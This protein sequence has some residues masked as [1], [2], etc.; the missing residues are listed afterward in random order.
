MGTGA[1]GS[2]GNSEGTLEEK[3]QKWDIKW[4]ELRK[5]DLEGT[6]AEKGSAKSL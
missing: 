5:S 6:R 4:K 2:S 1:L 3:T